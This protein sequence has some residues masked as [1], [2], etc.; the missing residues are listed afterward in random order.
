MFL[1]NLPAFSPT[2]P[3]VYRQFVGNGSE[4]RRRRVRFLPTSQ[5][6]YLLVLGLGYFFISPAILEVLM[7]EGLFDT[8]LTAQNYLTLYGIQLPAFRGL[9]RV[10][11]L[12]CL[13]SP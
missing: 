12:G 6:V 5:L 1:A 10:T 8:Q 13:T 9:V 2:L 11:S 3:I 4:G 7:R